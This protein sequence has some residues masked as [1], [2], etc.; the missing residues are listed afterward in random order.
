MTCCRRSSI[1]S[2]LSASQTIVWLD[3]PFVISVLVDDFVVKKSQNINHMAILNLTR[4]EVSCSAGLTESFIPVDACVYW[5]PFYTFNA[6]K[7]ASKNSPNGVSADSTGAVD[8]R[9]CSMI[10]NCVFR[11]KDITWSMSLL[12][13]ASVTASASSTVAAFEILLISRLS[14]H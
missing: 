7:H 5:F 3:N 10:K 6:L 8:F 9:P 4:W 11:K 2:L 1:Y 12:L 14:P 13:N